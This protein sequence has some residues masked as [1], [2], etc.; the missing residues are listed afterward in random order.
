MNLPCLRKTLHLAALALALCTTA[1]HGQT[2]YN[3]TLPTMQGYT[4]TS[5]TAFTF[6]GTPNTTGGA[7]LSFLWLAC[8]QGGFGTTGIEIDL[9]T[10]ASTYVNV[11]TETGGTLS[12]SNQSR[13]A[14]ITA[15]Q[16]QQ[17]FLY[18]GGTTVQGRVRIDDAC[19][20]GVGCS[21]SNDPVLTNLRLSYTV[22]AANFTSP[23]ASKCPGEV[24]QFSDLSINAPTSYSWSFPGGTPATSTLPNPA[25]QYSDPGQY[26]VT[27]TV[28]TADG[29]SSVTRTDFVTI[30]PLPTASA[31]ADQNLCEG[32]SV[33]LQASGGSTY[34]WIPSTGLATPN[35]AT[36]TATP[37]QTT[38]YTVLVTS[39]QGCQNSD[40]VV[41]N[42]VPAPEP[43]V[44]TGTG[45]LCA[46]DTLQLTASGATFYTWAPNLFISGTSGSTVNVWPAADQSWTVTGTDAFGCVGQSTVNVAVVPAPATPI[47]TWSD[48]VLSTASADLYQWYLDGTPLSEA[49]AQTLEPMG[50]G[51][52]VVIVTDANGCSATSAPYFFG[53]TGLNG[54]HTVN[55][56]VVPQPASEVLQVRGALAGTRYRLVD[57]KGRVVAEGTMGSTLQGIAVQHLAEGMHTLLLTTTDGTVRLPV[58]IGR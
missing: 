49:T 45:T 6:T 50:N 22:S 29:E 24:V 43:V 48:M 32:A 8:Y 9:R 33:N 16:L 44:N 17:A 41:V 10:G 40:Q 35:A 23:D 53:T 36:T 27:L 57:A 28:V 7:T 38:T 20:P 52:Y 37:A 13:T 34:Q 47:I 26:S 12:C 5:W 15:A 42:V 31:G 51:N 1:V 55:I 11:Y 18:G 39:A 54:Y 46:G 14:T 56:T 58:L 2:T 3:S 21:F 4:L 30:N 25:V 19:Q